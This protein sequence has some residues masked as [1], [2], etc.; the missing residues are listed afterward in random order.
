ML[1]HILGRPSSAWKR[2]EVI[3]TTLVAYYILKNK[4]R[5]PNILRTLNKRFSRYPAWKIILGTL[6]ISH[7]LKNSFLLLWLNAPE[8]LA[9]MYT[10]NFFRATWLMCAMDAGFFTAMHYKTKWIRDLLSVVFTVFYMFFPEAAHE[11]VKRYP[12]TIQ[13]MRTSWEKSTNPYLYAL[14]YFDRG[15]LKIRKDITFKRPTDTHSSFNLDKLPDVKARLYFPGTYEELKKATQIIFNIPGGGFVTM[16]PK[17][18][19]DYLSSWARELKI[20]VVSIDYGKAPEFPYPWAIEECFDAYRQVVETN[21]KC[22]GLEGWYSHDSKNSKKKDPI[23]IIMIGDSAMSDDHLDLLRSESTVEMDTFIRTKTE[24]NMRDPLRTNEAPKAVNILTDQVDS[25]ISRSYRLDSPS[26]FNKLKP[27]ILDSPPEAPK[28]RSGLSQ[29]SRMSFF[30]D[31]IIRPE[32]LRAMAI[33]YLAKSPTKI[34]VNQ[35]YYLSPLLAPET[36]L[37]QFPKTYFLC[38]EKDPLVDDTV[39]RLVIFAERLRD[40]KRKARLEWERVRDRTLNSPTGTSD[41]LRLAFDEPIEED[42]DHHLFS[43][44][45]HKMV[46]VKVLPGMSHGI[47]QMIHFLP[48]AKQAVSLLTGWI[49]ELLKEDTHDETSEITS[50]MISE[51]QEISENSLLLRRRASM[52]SRLGFGR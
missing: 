25:N 39:K 16:H 34:Y 36:I 29:S 51:M 21:G 48:E 33:M 22:I 42:I 2:G 20:P 47:F 5:P 41:H 45:P 18:H 44:D 6:T 15:Y 35:D 37:A 40:A 9:K 12:E 17:N 23:K 24:L 14:T 1:D 30:N 4:H 43:N 10:R 28:I 52:A 13:V 38:G 3:F 32:F 50:I 46:K 8:P 31:R 19:D 7:V 49:G 27:K 26:W 11:K